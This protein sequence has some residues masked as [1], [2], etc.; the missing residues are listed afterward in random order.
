MPQ[1]STM[2]LNFLRWQSLQKSVSMPIPKEH[3]NLARRLCHISLF[4]NIVVS[5]LERKMCSHGHNQPFP[6]IQ[7]PFGIRRSAFSTKPSRPTPGPPCTLSPWRYLKGAGV[8][9]FRIIFWTKVSPLG[10]SG[11]SWLKAIQAA[12][13]PM[14]LTHRLRLQNRGTYTFYSLMK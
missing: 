2:F 11:G 4:F 5:F 13:S 1:T 8:G 12:A 7:T 6:Y 10:K 14:T 3:F 9:A